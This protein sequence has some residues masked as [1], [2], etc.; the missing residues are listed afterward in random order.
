[1]GARLSDQSVSLLIKRYAHAIGLPAERISGH[2]LRAGFVT[3]AVR[4]GASLVSI[5]RQTGHAS[6]DMLARYIRELDPFVCN[7]HTQMGVT[8]K[9][10]GQ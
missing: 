4:A 7:A 8:V 6:L 5:Q 2:S 9:S 3:S 10:L 1:M